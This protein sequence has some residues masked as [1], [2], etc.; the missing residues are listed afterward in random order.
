MMY[1]R[2]D[3]LIAGNNDIREFIRA[4]TPKAGQAAKY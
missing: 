1:L 2:K 4:A 3:D